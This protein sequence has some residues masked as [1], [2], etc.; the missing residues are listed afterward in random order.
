MLDESTDIRD[1]AQLSIFI[2][3]IDDDFSFLEEL[4]SLELINGKTR[5]SVIFDKV[6]FCLKNLQIDSRKLI[7]VCTDG[8][9]SMVRRFAGAT[10]CA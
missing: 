5:G 4:L 10:T 9:P 8:A 2:R 6:K 7:S 1:A 3:G